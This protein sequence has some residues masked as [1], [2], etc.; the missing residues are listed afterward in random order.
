MVFKEG[1]LLSGIPDTPVV[2]GVSAR[3]K[4]NNGFN[5]SNHIIQRNPTGVDINQQANKTVFNDLGEGYANNGN[6]IVSI[7]NPENKKQKITKEIPRH[8]F[9]PENL[10]NKSVGMFGLTSS[11]KTT[12]VRDMLYNTRTEFPV[13]VVFCP[14]DQFNGDYS[15]I[16]PSALIHG[17]PTEDKIRQIKERQE[18]ATN[19]Y[20]MVNDLDVLKQ[21]YR[22]IKCPE[23][24]FLDK[25]ESKE[26]EEFKKMCKE[27]AAS[28][29]IEKIK[30]KY[31]KLKI[32][33]IKKHIRINA[34]VFEKNFNKLNELQQKSFKYRNFNPKILIIFDDCMNEINMMM[35][36]DKTKTLEG[37]FFKGRHINITMIYCLQ[38]VTKEG[39]SLAM[40]NNLFYSIFCDKGTAQAYFQ[41]SPSF[42]S[43]Q[44][45]AVKEMTN[46]IFENG[47][48]NKVLYCREITPNV[49]YLK[50]DLH[51]PFTIGSKHV[52]AYCKTIEKDKK[53]EYLSN[54]K[55]AK[56]LI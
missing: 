54:M 3:R 23:K 36:K 11:G 18:E 32:E 33:F 26:K 12:I 4:K 19:I 8:Q 49:Q 47:K 28:S 24:Y 2:K 17:A 7:P 34:R 21:L 39:L 27:N 20:K 42:T 50:A 29:D 9:K 31:H 53:E 5:H 41:T 10:V 13:I 48:Y 37:F 16:L 6:L 15:S 22:M 43:N 56:I 52:K 46:R 35:K 1:D 38:A 55:K 25:I 45:N 14:T 30:E 44:K 51:S 40:R